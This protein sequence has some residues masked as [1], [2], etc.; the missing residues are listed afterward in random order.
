MSPPCAP[1]LLRWPCSVLLS[2]VILLVLIPVI[3]GQPGFSLTSPTR[4]KRASNEIAKENP[5]GRLRISNTW[6][7]CEE[8]QSCTGKHAMHLRSPAIGTG[9]SLAE[10]ANGPTSSSK[11]NFKTAPETVPSHSG[12]S[13]QQK[14][15]IA[16]PLRWLCMPKSALPKEQSFVM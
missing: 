11:S 9:Q 6:P 3:L 1:T 16:F 13:K 5:T 4:S 2:M 8:G 10:A 7:H 14:L 12:S 15:V